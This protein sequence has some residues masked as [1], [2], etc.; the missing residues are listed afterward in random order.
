L[1][2]TVLS[3]TISD[4]KIMFGDSKFNFAGIRTA[5]KSG[6]QKSLSTGGSELNF[7]RIQPKTWQG[8]L[9]G[10]ATIEG[11]LFTTGL[12]WELNQ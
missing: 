6:E 4:M 10:K 2:N 11:D 7:Q 3:D 9:K 5:A 1:K 8:A 12:E